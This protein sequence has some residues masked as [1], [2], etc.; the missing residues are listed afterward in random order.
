LKFGLRQAKG[1][2]LAEMSSGCVFLAL[3][4]SFLAPSLLVTAI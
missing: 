2:V 4:M 1:A 3:A